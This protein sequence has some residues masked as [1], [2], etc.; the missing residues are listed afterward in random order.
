M[1]EGDL[2]ASSSRATVV[3]LARRGSLLQESAGRGGRTSRSRAAAAR[4]APRRVSFARS[5][6]HRLRVAV[7]DLV[8]AAVACGPRSSASLVV[9][10]LLVVPVD[11]VDVAVG[12]V[13]QVDEAATQASLASRKS[14]PWLADVAGALRLQH[15]HVEPLAVDVAHEDLAAVL[16]GP[17]AAE[18]DHRRRSGRGRRRRESE[19]LLPPCGV[20]A[21]VVAVVGDRLDVVVG[22]RVEVL[23]RLALVAA[24]LDDVEAVR[25]DAG[26][27]ERLA[28]VVEVERPTGCSCRGRRPR[29]RAAS[30]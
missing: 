29:R 11:E 8:D 20:G 12:A 6:V 10:G 9:A 16:R 17:G 19:R 14:G 15:V 30:G 3:E 25:D 18:V 5:T 4:P 1:L 22:V 28:V 24:A 7:A 23:A 26:L 27:D 21:D 13:A 2:R